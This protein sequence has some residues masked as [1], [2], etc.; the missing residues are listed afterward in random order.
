MFIEDKKIVIR[1]FG[2]H[3]QKDEAIE[4]L[5]KLL[6]EKDERLKEAEKVL[7]NLQEQLRYNGASE[8]KKYFEKWG[9][10]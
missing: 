9:S 7:R 8:I 1:S 6:N 4:S 2:T 10:Q 3:R 5:G